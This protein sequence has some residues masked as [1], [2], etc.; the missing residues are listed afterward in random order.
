M[1]IGRSSTWK[2][3]TERSRDW[4]RLLLTQRR[5]GAT[6]WLNSRCAAAPPRENPAEPAN[7]I[8]ITNKDMPYISALSNYRFVLAFP[9]RFGIARDARRIAPV[10]TGH[11]R[12][13]RA[14]SGGRDHSVERE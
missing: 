13:V 14:Q 7:S 12:R 11:T 2:T 1:L 10:P 5:S 6:I 9:H 3:S 4:G 8:V